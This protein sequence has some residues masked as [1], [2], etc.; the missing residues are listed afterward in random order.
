MTTEKTEKQL[1][2]PEPE[3]KAPEPQTGWE[4]HLWPTAN[5]RP[6][7]LRLKRPPEKK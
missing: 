5:G 3:K 7:V 1:K 6:R 4:N 2:L